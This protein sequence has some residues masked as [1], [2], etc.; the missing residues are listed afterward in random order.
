MS[1]RVLAACFL[2]TSAAV[3]V[4]AASYVPPHGAATTLSAHHRHPAGRRMV[5]A[6]ELKFLWRHEERPH[7][8]ALPREERHGWLRQHWTAMNEQ[9]KA[10]KTAELRAKWNA[11]PASVQTTLLE[12]IHDRREA[13]RMRHRGGNGSRQ[14][15]RQG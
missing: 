14:Q 4:M 3:P 6:P 5:L 1:F 8:K 11:L 7:L 10:A 13:R 2:L 9:E 15:E 12:K